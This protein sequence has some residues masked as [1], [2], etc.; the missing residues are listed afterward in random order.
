MTTAIGQLVNVTF[1][2]E[3]PGRVRAAAPAC[4]TLDAAVPRVGVGNFPSCPASSAT[5][6]APTVT[7]SAVAQPQ[8]I[9]LTKA[10]CV[11]VQYS[12][13]IGVSTAFKTQKCF[14]IGVRLADGTTPRSIVAITAVARTQP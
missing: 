6:A 4:I 8:L 14:D 7:P 12:A 11:N 9:N 1:M 5:V 10:T 2:L 13:L 3:T